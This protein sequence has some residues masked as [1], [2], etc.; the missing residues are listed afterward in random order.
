MEYRG[1]GIGTGALLVTAGALL[2]AGIALLL[3]PRS[4]KET[5]R[6]IT[7]LARKA[8]RRAEKA[9]HEAAG[10]VYGAVDEAGDRAA[11]ILGRGKELARDAEK[12]L[13]G[14]IKEGER[15]LEKQK[16]RLSRLIA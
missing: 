14:V 13:S 9:A 5:R 7:R 12:E 6:E 1:N 4:G 16:S 11:E 8:G 15:R 3:A 2:G 10:S